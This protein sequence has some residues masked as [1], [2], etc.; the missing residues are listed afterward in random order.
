M[1]SFF[2]YSYEAENLQCHQLVTA[3][4]RSTSLIQVR[5]KQTKTDPFRKGVE[6][7]LGLLYAR[8]CPVGA[9]IDYIVVRSATQ[10]PLFIF[11]SGTPLTRQAL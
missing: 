8:I 4:Q 11:L 7:F 1:Y 9:L 10:G 3:I 2:I 5:L 6:V